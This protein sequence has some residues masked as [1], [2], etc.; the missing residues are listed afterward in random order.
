MSDG[1][2]DRVH[3]AQL[4]MGPYMPMVLLVII[5]LCIWIG[6]MVIPEVLP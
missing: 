3:R 5:L 4:T 6:A 2:Q 1:K